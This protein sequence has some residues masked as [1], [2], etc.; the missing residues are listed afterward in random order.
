MTWIFLGKYNI[1]PSVF[2]VLRGF[3]FVYILYSISFSDFNISYRIR[4]FKY[5]L[6]SKFYARLCRRISILIEWEIGTDEIF[7]FSIINF[8]VCSSS[9]SFA[10]LPVENLNIN[11]KKATFSSLS[12][13]L[14]QYIL[15]LIFFLLVLQK[16]WMQLLRFP[17]PFPCF[18]VLV[19]LSYPRHL[20]A[21][22]VILRD[23]YFLP[24]LPPS[25]LIL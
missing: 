25:F 19:I 13:I 22:P 17:V 7:I 11:I 9:V 10:N 18:Y 14:L 4:Y 21:F 23:P 20:L 16:K 12:Y 15:F 5:I 3:V 2:A 8:E 1:I 24:S 6:L